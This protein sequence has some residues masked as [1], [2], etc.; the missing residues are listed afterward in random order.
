MTASG[1]DNDRTARLA[2]ALR[3]NLKRR[4]EQ[5]RRKAG[6]QKA[7]VVDTIAVNPPQTPPKG[8]ETG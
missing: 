7:D 8:G 6:T 5:A 2:Q 3:A 1:K 4:R